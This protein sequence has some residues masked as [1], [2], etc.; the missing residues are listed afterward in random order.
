MQS[1]NGVHRI[2]HRLECGE[3]EIMQIESEV[4]PRKNSAHIG[5][6]K[7]IGLLPCRFGGL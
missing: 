7:L 1:F 5:L 4:R 6:S 3:K 2:G